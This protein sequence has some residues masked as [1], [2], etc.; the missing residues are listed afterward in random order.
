MEDNNKQLLDEVTKK[1]LEKALNSDA[2]SDEGKAAF[3]QAMDAVDRQIEVTK[4]EEA[5]EE[6]AMRQE[7]AKEE[8]T[9]N[10]WLKVLEIGATVILVPVVSA[11]CN[12]V[13][14]DKY[15]EK[16][17]NFEKDY[18]FTTTAGKQTSKFFKFGK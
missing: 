10:K 8:R 6:Q 18:S 2:D 16:I 14:N 3:K 15:M 4:L 9:Q 17:C 7:L 1:Y 13:S 5:S 11:I 12:Y